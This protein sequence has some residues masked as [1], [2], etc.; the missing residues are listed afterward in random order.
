VGLRIRQYTY[1]SI[2]S[3][4]LDAAAIAALVSIAPDQVLVRGSRVADPPVPRAH[5]WKLVANEK[6]LRVDEQATRLLER[7][8]PVEAQLLELA[9]DWGCSLALQVVR[10]F[11]NEAGEE[12]ILPSPEARFQKLP[13]QHQLLG[14]H[15]EADDLAFLAR[16]GADIDVDEY[17]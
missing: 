8:R 3:D 4:D 2:R 6:G 9:A 5:A 14:W 11:D 1:F 13:G 16:I 17:G 7:L 12:E 15:L 10:D